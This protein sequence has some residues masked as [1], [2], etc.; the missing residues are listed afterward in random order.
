MSNAAM[1]PIAK[2]YPE[3]TSGRPMDLCGIIRHSSEHLQLSAHVYI[4]KVCKVWG[5]TDMDDPWQSCNVPDLFH[6]WKESSHTWNTHIQRKKR[7]RWTCEDRLRGWKRWTATHLLLD[8]RY[9]APQTSAS[10]ETHSHKSCLRP[11]TQAFTTRNWWQL[12]IF[13]V[14]HQNE[15][16]GTPQLPLRFDFFVDLTNLFLIMK[17][18]PSSSYSSVWCWI[19]FLLLIKNRLQTDIYTFSLVIFCSLNIF[20]LSFYH[21]IRKNIYIHGSS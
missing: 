3:W 10:P 4:I 16:L 15:P 9:E 2:P 5:E 11:E 14:D 17:R 18:L 13:W 7:H 12:N 8:R 20:S 21:Y 19:F 6:G 1:F